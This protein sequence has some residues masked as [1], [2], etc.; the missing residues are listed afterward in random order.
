MPTTKSQMILKK[1]IAMVSKEWVWL[2][3]F[4]ALKWTVAIK[5]A[6]S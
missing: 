1:H 6:V 4:T 5:S 2:G 3:T